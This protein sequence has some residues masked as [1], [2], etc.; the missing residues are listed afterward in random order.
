M[1][2]LP[3]FFYPVKLRHSR[4]RYAGFNR[5]NL[6]ICG[7]ARYTGKRFFTDERMKSKIVWHDGKFIPFKKA[8]VPLLTHSLHYGSGVFEGIRCYP[9]PKGPAVFRLSGH[10]RRLLYSANAMLMEV[11][12]KPAEIKK[13]VRQLI[14]KNGLKECYIRP[15]IYYGEK[16]GLGLDGVPLHFAIAVWPWG[17]YLG[18]DVVDVKISR[19]MRIHPETSDTAAKISGHYINSTMA[20]MEAKRSG[21]DEA[22]LL[23]HKGNIAEGPGE[24]IFFVRGRT[25]STPPLGTIL[26]GL[27]RACVLQIARDLGY[28]V[29][30]KNVKPKDIKSYDEAFFT[31]TAAE[32][33]AIGSINRKKIGNGKEGKVTRHIRETYSKAVH[34]EIPKYEK[35]LTYV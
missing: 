17:K 34:G 4:T 26:S 33:N 23:D 8:V 16:M 14:K 5:V 27:T 29:E 6:V 19:V 2:G 32:V 21:F 20:S 22:L 30:E 13:I 18:K 31:G 3:L 25:L 24:N 11:K 15:I 7:N 12:Y 28:K 10:I 1:S 9:T 35:W